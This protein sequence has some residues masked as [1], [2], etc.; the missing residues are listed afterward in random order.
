MS[1]APFVDFDQERRQ[2]TADWQTVIMAGIILM[3]TR[4]QH[5][6][7]ILVAQRTLRWDKNQLGL[8]VFVVREVLRKYGPHL[9][10]QHP[11]EIILH[12]RGS[13]TQGQPGPA[14]KFTFKFAEIKFLEFIQ[15][16][17]WSTN[18]MVVTWNMHAFCTVKNAIF[19]FS[20]VTFFFAIWHETTTRHCHHENS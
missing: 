16:N 20:R 4:L 11:T 19:V 13:R 17:A 12:R 15:T 10:S 2:F 7:R 6:L 5:Q 8:K 18:T 9:P 14:L 3:W 1:V